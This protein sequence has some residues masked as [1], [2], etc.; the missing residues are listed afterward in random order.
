MSR[1]LRREA[2]DREC[3]I[4]L[5]GCQVHPCCLCHFRVIGIS[6]MGMKSPDLLG[7]WGCYSCHTK[8]DTILRHDTETQLDFAKAVFR[9]QAILLK[10][11]KIK[12][13]E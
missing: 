6:G 7:A 3:Q 5:E 11:G 8:V 10:E 1:N 2:I 4:R 12:Y 13:G 9:T